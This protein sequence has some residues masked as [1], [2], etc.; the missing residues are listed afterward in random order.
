[1]RP[2]F[3]TSMALFLALSGCVKYQLLPDDT[4][5]DTFDS[6]KQL[7]DEH[8]LKRTGAKKREYAIE[9]EAKP[10]DW[11]QSSKECFDLV[12]Q[13]AAEQSSRPPAVVKESSKFDKTAGVVQC[14]ITAYIWPKAN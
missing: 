3:L 12:N 5:E 4:I 11:T 7:Y 8:K 1:M 2:A 14:Q 9:L 6:T 13:R 10:Q